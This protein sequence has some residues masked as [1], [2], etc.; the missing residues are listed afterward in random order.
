MKRKPFFY[1]EL[2]NDWKARLQC[3]ATSNINSKALYLKTTVGENTS[4]PHTWRYR[5]D[6][7]QPSPLILDHWVWKCTKKI[8]FSSAK[9]R[10]RNANLLNDGWPS[11]RANWRELV[12]VPPNRELNTSSRLKSGFLKI[13]DNESSKPQIIAIIGHRVLSSF[14][15][16]VP[17]S[18]WLS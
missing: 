10:N 4:L 9:H 8:K 18:T 2:L 17:Y 14:I 16:G 5:F 6:K 7:K 13:S 15:I 3:E 1:D 11:K 12:S